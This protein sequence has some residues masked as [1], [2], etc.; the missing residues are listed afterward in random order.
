MNK[1]IGLLPT[2]SRVLLGLVFTVFGLN[3]FLQFLPMPPMEGAAGAFVG[4]L[5]ASGYL[6]PLLKGVEVV[7]GLMLLANRYVPLALTLLAPIVVN[8]AL[9]HFVLTPGEIGMAVALLAIEIYLAWSYRGAF[10]GVLDATARPSA[11][12]ESSVGATAPAA[13]R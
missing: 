6:F 2:A 13:A 4:A 3:G 5:A 10:R 1:V 7:A 12:E 8:I 11:R 9:F